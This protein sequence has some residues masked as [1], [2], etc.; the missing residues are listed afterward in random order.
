[1]DSKSYP[2]VLNS[3]QNQ[4]FLLDAW[5]LYLHLGIALTV[6]ALG[7][8]RM[9]GSWFGETVQRYKQF[10]NERCREENCIFFRLKTNLIKKLHYGAMLY[11]FGMYKSDVFTSLYATPNINLCFF[12]LGMWSG[13]PSIL[14]ISSRQ[15]LHTMSSLV[16]QYLATSSW[17]CKVVQCRVGRHAFSAG[18]LLKINSCTANWAS[19]HVAE[20]LN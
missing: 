3:P 18:R 11:R 16:I 7:K 9:C 5:K 10:S 15:R 17:L 14:Q 2:L 12:H 1:M 6:H 20:W 4:L 19:G 13:C 8:F